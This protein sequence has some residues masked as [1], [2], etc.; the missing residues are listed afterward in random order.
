MEPRR[1]IQ[2][3]E[4]PA[5]Q[6]RNWA[7]E[8]IGWAALIL[9]L[10]G[11]CAGLFGSGPLSTAR[12]EAAGLTLTYKRILRIQAPASVTLNLGQGAREVRLFISRDWLEDVTIEYVSPPDAP[13][14]L[15]G[16]GMEFV[17]PAAPEVRGGFIRIDFRPGRM[18]WQ[19]GEMRL[20]GGPPLRFGALVLP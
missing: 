16:D 15:R 18:G 2:I 13:A 14:L 4:D 6:R 19:R 7:F 1:S 20:D 3:D 5:F 8:R 11:A 10:A 17:F 9:I 12:T